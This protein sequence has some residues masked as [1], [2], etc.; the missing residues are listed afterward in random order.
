MACLLFITYLKFC[1]L[2]SKLPIYKRITSREVAR[3][4]GGDAE[5]GD[6]SVE[7]LNYYYYKNNMHMVKSAKGYTMKC[8]SPFYSRPHPT[9]QEWLPGYP[10]GNMSSTHRHMQTHPQTLLL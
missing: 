6:C 2:D 9:C 7:V 5:L 3:Y 4:S 10:S 1:Q 8:D